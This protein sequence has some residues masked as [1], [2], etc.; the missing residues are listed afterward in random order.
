MIRGLGNMAYEETLAELGLFGL[1]CYLFTFAQPLQVLLSMDRAMAS[2]K[3]GTAAP[4]IHRCC[5]RKH[6]APGQQPSEG[7]SQD[8]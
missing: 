4:G 8:L 6:S 5:C 7:I 3:L 1:G 2:S